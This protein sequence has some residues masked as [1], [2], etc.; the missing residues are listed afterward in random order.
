MDV[1]ALKSVENIR[2]MIAQYREE[3]EHL[4]MKISPESSKLPQNFREQNLERLFDHC[5]LL[6]ISQ[7]SGQM[8]GTW[9]IALIGSYSTK[10][11]SLGSFDSHGSL[12]RFIRVDDN[13]GAIRVVIECSVRESFIPHLTS[14]GNWRKATLSDKQFGSH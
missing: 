5:C 11:V 4:F 9:P 2:R 1:Q 10:S 3:Q 7:N 6:S 8:L 14:I 12:W 13:H